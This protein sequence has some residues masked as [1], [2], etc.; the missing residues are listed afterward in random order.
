MEPPLAEGR[1]PATTLVRL[2]PQL[3]R[4]P[5]RSTWEGL[6]ER[7]GC[8]S[9]GPSGSLPPVTFHASAEALPEGG[10]AI[11]FVAG[12]LA[13]VHAVVPLLQANALPGGCSVARLQ[14]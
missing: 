8:G 14:G 9:E 3:H 11:D 12:E 5:L 10:T 13:A 7:H 2:G 4:P 6:L 1:L